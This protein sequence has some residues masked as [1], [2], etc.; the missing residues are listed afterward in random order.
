MNIGG[1]IFSIIA[2]L[3][4][5]CKHGAGVPICVQGKMYAIEFGN[6]IYNS[7]IQI[8]Y[9]IGLCTNKKPTGNSLS[10][11]TKVQVSGPLQFKQET[12]KQRI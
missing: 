8:I 11:M 1:S 7:L 9:K 10:I 4:I 12:N 2:I 3:P 6:L 5:Q